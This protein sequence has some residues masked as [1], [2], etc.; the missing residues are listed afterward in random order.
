MEQNFKEKTVQ[1]YLD[2]YIFNRCENF[3]TKVVASNN[4]LA[5]KS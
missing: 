4:N 1:R 3:G 5:G 2:I